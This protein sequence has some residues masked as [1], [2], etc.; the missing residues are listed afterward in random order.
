MLATWLVKGAAI[1]ASASLKDNPI[2]P[3]FKIILCLFKPVF[4]AP[5]SFAPSPHI[6]TYILLFNSYNFET[7]KA[8]SSG[9]ILAKIAVFSNIFLKIFSYFEGQD[10]IYAK[11]CLNA[12]PVI[13][14]E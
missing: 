9:F 4:K 10:A 3:L 1:E 11:R 2:S 5:Q 7:N 13:A 12:P 8:L 6:P 14:N